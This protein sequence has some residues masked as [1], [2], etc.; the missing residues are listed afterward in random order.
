[1]ISAQPFFRRA[2]W[3]AILLLGL[4]WILFSRSGADSATSGPS[5]A[6]QPGFLS[7]AF[8]LT[9]RSG[10]LVSLADLRGHPVIL[11]FWASWCAP[12][13]AE[14]PALQAVADDYAASGLVVLAV[15][16]AF[17]D[18]AAD[19]AAF[20]SSHSLT[21]PVLFDRDGRVSRLYQIHSLPTTFFI[22]PDG[23]IRQV[24][25][26]GPMSAASLRI[27]AEALLTEAP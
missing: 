20:L 11:N 14:M 18:E 23:V 13:R 21:L 1:M 10:R 26:G 27:R 19:A 4:G 2:L 6:P 9:D 15:N 7:P 22:G 24:V 16:A 12:C 8:E 3:A 17:Q 5:V 25:I